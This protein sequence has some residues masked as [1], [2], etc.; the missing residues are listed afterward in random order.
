MQMHP[1]VIW[2]LY[3]PSVTMMH[4][5]EIMLSYNLSWASKAFI[6]I[7]DKLPVK[8]N[9]RTSWCH[10][11]SLFLQL[12]II[13]YYTVHLDTFDACIYHPFSKKLKRWKVAYSL[14]L[15][16]IHFS[17]SSWH[18]IYRITYSSWIFTDFIWFL[19]TIVLTSYISQYYSFLLNIEK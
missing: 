12:S 13:L 8:G 7:T 15:Q 17:R 10:F 1:Q 6:H 19:S 2:S 4:E 16:V 5:T 18:A 14:E 11:C 9:C 3:S